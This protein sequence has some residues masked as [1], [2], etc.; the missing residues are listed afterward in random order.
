AALLV[1]SLSGQQDNCIERSNHHLWIENDVLMNPERN[2][3]HG[4]TNVLGLR[5]SLE[6]VSSDLV[7][8]VDIFVVSR[9]DHLNSIQPAPIGNVKAPQL[10]HL[11]CAF[12]ADCDA[13]GKLIWYRS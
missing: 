3:L 1:T 4:F 6:E 7:K 9:I 8:H 13:A 2:S 11:S 10:R 12:G 5:K